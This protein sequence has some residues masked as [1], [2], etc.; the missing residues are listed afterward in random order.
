ML[1]III[2]Y[3]ACTLVIFWAGHRLAIYGDII[4]EKTGISK[5]WIGFVLIAFVGSLPELAS[6]LSATAVLHVPDLAIGSLFGICLYNLLILAVI[7]VVY[8]LWGKGTI[9]GKANV[10]HVLTAGLGIVLLGLAVLGIVSGGLRPPVMYGNVSLYA[11]T[12]FATYIFAQT[13]IYR[14]ERKRESAFFDQK[15]KKLEHQEFTKTDL[16]QAFTRFGLYSIVVVMAGSWLPI[17][18]TQIANTYMLTNAVAGT[19]IVGFSLVLPKAMLAWSYFMIGAV[20]MAI[21]A[22]LTSNV[23]SMVIIFIADLFY[24]VSIL[25]IATPIL[26]TMG[27]V[28]IMMTALAIAGLIYRTELKEGRHIGW[29]YSGLILL[30]LA[31]IYLVTH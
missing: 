10:G 8:N 15:I 21:G 9:L 12:I 18:A 29:D 19:L 7:D 28:A 13:I 22:I 27:L 5:L 14:F 26:A 25:A 16:W 30:F 3:L 6:S 31:A 1:E 11:L 20:D 17:L 23:F 4:A 24:P 2:K